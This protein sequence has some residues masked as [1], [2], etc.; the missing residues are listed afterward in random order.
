MTVPK[1]VVVV[2]S[3]ILLHVERKRNKVLQRIMVVWGMFMPAAV[4]AA[5]PVG[6][7]ESNYKWDQPPEP[8]YPD[9]VFYGWNEFSACC[10]T[11]VADDWSCDTDDPVAAIHWW[12]SFKGW[13]RTYPPPEPFDHFHF[14][15]W[16]DVPAGFDEPFSHP[17]TVIHE[18][19]AVDYTWHFA[20]WDYDPRTGEY[21]AAFRFDYHLD[22]SEYFHQ[23]SGENIY[24]ISIGAGYC[25][26]EPGPNPWGWKT[27]PRDPS[28]QA[29]D[30]AVIMPNPE[31]MYTPPG[32]TWEDIG[33]G[34]P[35]HWPGPDRSWDMAFELTARSA[36]STT[37]QVQPP[38]PHWPGLHAHDWA[39]P[40]H[41]VVL[42]DQWRCQGGDVTDLYWYG[43]YELDYPGQEIRG[44]GI[45][46]FHLS[47]HANAPSDPWCL[48][49]DPEIRGI[50]VPFI[51]TMEQP[52]GLVNN[53]G[54]PIYRYKY[55]LPQPFEQHEGDVYW[56]DITAISV[57]PIDPPYWR[58]QE[59]ER[60][61]LPIICPAAGKSYPFAPAP[62]ESI[63][64]PTIP[65]SYSD[66]A[67][68]VTSTFYGELYIKWSQPPEPYVP[69]N[70]YHGW[71]EF[72]V[73]GDNIADTQIVADDWVCTSGRPVTGIHW[74]GSFIGWGEPTPPMLP[75]RFG[76]HIAIWTDEPAGPDNRFSHPDVVLWETT[77]EDVTVEF[78]GWDFDPRSWDFDLRNPMAPPEACFKFEHSLDNDDWFYQ[79]FGENIY[80]VSIAAVY[81]AD[82]V[83]T[84]PWGWKTRPRALNSPAP[85]DAVKIWDPTNPVVG[86]TY[87][88][89]QP[90][91][92]PTPE[93]SWDTAFRLTTRPPL[94]PKW[95]QLPHDGGEG[96]DAPS[97]LW[98][99]EM[100]PVCPWWQDPDPSLP[101]LRAHDWEDDD[102]DY[103]WITL[104]DAWT[105]GDGDVI[106][107]G[108]YGNYELDA[109]HE[110]IR[111]SGINE[112]HLSL[113]VAAPQVPWCLP[114]L[115]L[116]SMA[117]PFSV[118]NETATGMFNIDG[119]MIY[120]YRLEVPW[121][122]P[123]VSDMPY[124]FDL[125]AHAVDPA[126]PALWRWQEAGRGPMITD[127]CVAAERLNGG[128]WHTIEWPTDPPSYS[129]MAFRVTVGPHEVNKVV[130]DDFVSDGRPIEAVRWWG[131]YWDEQYA[132]DYPTPDELHVVDG[133]LI[134]FH[135]PDPDG[136][137]PPEAMPSDV[138]TV[139]GVYFAPADAV[140]IMG[141]D[142]GDCFGHGLYVYQIDLD[143]CCL[144]CSEADPRNGESP[145]HRHAFLEE[146]GYRYWLDIQAV[147][148]VR[149]VS[150][151][152]PCVMEYT[153]HL[154]S[155]NTPDGHF[156]GWHTSP[157]LASGYDPMEE[158]CTGR[159]IGPCV[160]HTPD[161]C[162]DYGDWEKQPWLCPDTPSAPPSEVHMAF[163]LLTTSVAGD[164][165]GD[166]KV[167]LADYAVFYDCITGPNGGPIEPE[168][169]CADLDVDNDVD[170]ADFGLFENGFTGS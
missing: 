25:G 92:W 38:D 56:L 16:T 28:S 99:Y 94:V 114:G 9:N 104:A 111:G 134:S 43:N 71:N 59:A 39:E 97:D 162:W 69:E 26:M 32:T 67:F 90:I 49:R 126:D 5:S 115:E 27:R 95:S 33:G 77:V 103:N 36:L 146:H 156:W 110:E 132:P 139:L 145:A 15:F 130:A 51:A 85:E 102:G 163:D 74:W 20:G 53:E 24:W 137:C 122:R 21:E 166:G 88:D 165:T 17:G 35:I 107:F 140:T 128:P 89:G 72:S 121:P 161:D 7:I 58:W 73:Y 70:A 62:W 50:D 100:S 93:D 30:E 159:I 78:A 22:P 101:G 109:L 65:P 138:P 112:F 57:D 125:E 79:G 46:H 143:R 158:A 14:F 142:M 133:W 131:S 168:C 66:L 135:H 2:P 44:S 144:V 164:C 113:H 149:W 170:L 147:V 47:I 127:P 160:P 40:Y 60:G 150:T 34:G 91:W 52:T 116:W 55:V 86:S 75:D 118:V 123:Q 1:P 76:F 108:W 23:Q 81:P 152:A 148:G 18:I 155:P 31:M 136:V 106:R 169:E 154:P 84:Y 120:F 87:I 11:L 45:Q 119:S 29:P 4:L 96:F 153:G 151:V 124:F 83:V 48:P 141:I 105:C 167:D 6:E 12:G 82:T 19:F 64:W 68:G 3:S 117:V 13:R 37:K 157:G 63:V 98:W 129:D 42:A 80:W 8:A 10:H 61:T 41:G 54:S